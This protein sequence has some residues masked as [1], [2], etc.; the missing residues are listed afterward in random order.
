L[1]RSVT[2]L[3]DGFIN[4]ASP[5]SESEPSSNVFGTLV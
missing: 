3:M 2:K 5:A 4:P 1:R